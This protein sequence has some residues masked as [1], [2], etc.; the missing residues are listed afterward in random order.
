MR[1]ITEAAQALQAALGAGSTLPQILDTLIRLTAP[2]AAPQASPRPPWAHLLPLTLAAF[3]ESGA[4]LGPRFPAL[5]VSVWATGPDAM[6]RAIAAE[7]RITTREVW[8][9]DRLQREARQAGLDASVTVARLVEVL[10]G[11]VVNWRPP[12]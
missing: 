7:W 8:R 3:A 4:A 11:Q 10:G 9:L 12:A 1:P 6:A 2:T 5:G